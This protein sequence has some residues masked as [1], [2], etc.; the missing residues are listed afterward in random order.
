M[1]TLTLISLIFMVKTTSL[2][3]TIQ[4]SM[5]LGLCRQQVAV[6]STIAALL[7]TIPRKVTFDTNSRVDYLSPYSQIQPK[8]QLDGRYPRDFETPKSIEE[9]RYMDG[10]ISSYPVLFPPNFVSVVMDGQA[11]VYFIGHTLDRI[12]RDYR[13]QSDITSSRR[14]RCG[15]GADLLLLPSSGRAHKLHA[16][17]EFLGVERYGETENFELSETHTTCGGQRRGFYG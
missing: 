6:V 11:D 17:L 2:E 3:G 12:L 16:L 15:G 5:Y 7:R 9:F 13:L 8:L 14:L 1:V 10:V 4:A